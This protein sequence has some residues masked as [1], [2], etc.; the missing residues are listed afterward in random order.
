MPFACGAAVAAISLRCAAVAVEEVVLP[1]LDV[2]GQLLDEDAAVWRP[3]AA[4]RSC[5]RGGAALVR[6]RGRACC[7]RPSS[8]SRPFMPRAQASAWVFSSK[9]TKQK[10]GAAHRCRPACRCLLFSRT[11]P[12]RIHHLLVR[13]EIEIT[14][15]N[16]AADPLSGGTRGLRSRPRLRRAARAATAARGRRAAG[17]GCGCAA[18]GRGSGSA[19]GPAAGSRRAAAA[20][21]PWRRAAAASGRA[22]AA[23]AAGAAAGAA[24][25]FLH[26]L[27]SLTVLNVSAGSVRERSKSQPFGRA[28]VFLA[29]VQSSDPR[30]SALGRNRMKQTGTPRLQF[31]SRAIALLLSRH[32]RVSAP[33]SRPWAALATDDGPS[34]VDAEPQPARRTR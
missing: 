33:H 26:E 4:R 6:R 21:P 28:R 10:R 31:C 18:T 23:R 32:R 34:Q 16:L 7:A 12:R 3:A 13:V 15:I 5:R 29:V 2:V 8:S 30:G 17:C 24:A 11:R 14:N 27:E 20:A 19:S 25:N 1:F 9:V 22:P